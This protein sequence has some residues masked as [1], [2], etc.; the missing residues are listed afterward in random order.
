MEFEI[1]GGKGV[2]AATGKMYT[3]VGGSITTIVT[4]TKDSRYNYSYDEKVTVGAPGPNSSLFYR[5]IASQAN[6]PK[7][8]VLKPYKVDEF[9]DCN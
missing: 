4:S 1:I 9:T 2:G 3:A 6:G 8:N 5:L 7:G